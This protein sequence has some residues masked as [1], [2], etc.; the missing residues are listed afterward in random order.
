MKEK[1]A[2]NPQD[3][4]NNSRQGYIFDPYDDWYM[5]PYWYGYGYPWYGPTYY[6]GY[7]GGGH[8]GHHGGHRGKRNDHCGKECKQMP[9]QPMP[10]EPM[11]ID[12][13][14][15]PMEPIQY[16]PMQPI[17]ENKYNELKSLE[18]KAN[19]TEIN[20]TII[21]IEQEH[22]WLMKKLLKKGIAYAECKKIMY[23][24]LLCSK[25]FHK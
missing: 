25:K 21:N 7:Y 4:G 17:I 1:S 20:N 2:I 19:I 13:E 18:K 24:I 10:M 5:Y 3:G 15:V 16:A 14:S 23:Q 9:M 12:Q 11:P 6:G 8:G 22:P